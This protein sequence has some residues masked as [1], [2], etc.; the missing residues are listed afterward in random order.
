[1]A[2]ITLRQLRAFVE[3]CRTEK[4]VL[5]S[6]RLHVTPSALS[7]LLKQ[8]EGEL[9]ITLFERSSRKLR[10]TD[11]AL[12]AVELAER[13]LANTR[14]LEDE[15]RNFQSFA[16]GRISLAA[17]PGLVAQLLPTPVLR[18]RA[19]YPSVAVS[20]EDC[21]PDQLWSLVSSGH[22][23]LGMGSPD[24]LDKD[25]EWD[26]LA[27][28]RICIIC[29]RDHPLSAY[30]SLKWDVL[31]EHEFMTVK[32]ESG[33]RRLID[34]TL[35]KLGMNVRPTIEL[36]YLESVLALTQAGLAIAVLPS[37]FVQNSMYGSELVVKPLVAPTV[38]RD[39]LLLRKRGRALS[40]AATHF[41]EIMLSQLAETA[42]RGN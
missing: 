14:Q 11:T 5:A 12:H 27:R 31:A 16:R 7:M 36:T 37:F 28:D 24:V 41:R 1:M 39:I 25:L 6:Q 9:G 38:K 17:T 4:L 13:V 20:I 22:C 3:V 26:V 21:A 34:Q 23:D 10:P 2:N 40:T 32:R 29:R 15:V 35:L 19:T 18:F 30:R 33:I 42:K 8:L